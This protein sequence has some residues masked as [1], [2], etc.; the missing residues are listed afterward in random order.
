MV[1]CLKKQANDISGG[2]NLIEI[3]ESYFNYLFKL[4]DNA[5]LLILGIPK[6]VE[7]CPGDLIFIKKR[8][9]PIKTQYSGIVSGTK[10]IGP[11]F[12]FFTF[13]ART[14]N[15]IDFYIKMLARGNTGISRNRIKYLK[16]IAGI[17]S[18]A[19]DYNIALSQLKKINSMF[20]KSLYRILE[21]IISLL[22][23][24]DPYT[25]GHSSNVKRISFLIA[26]EMKLSIPA[27]NRIAVSAVLHD[28]GKIGI[29]DTIL[30]KPCFLDNAEFEE[31]KKH[32]L[33]GGILLEQV[34]NFKDIAKIVM[35]HHERYDG[36]G[37]PMGLSGDNISIEARIIALSDACDAI[38]SRRPYRDKKCLK[39]AV[40][41]IKSGS[42]TQFDPAVVNAFMGL[43]S[44]NFS[45]LNCG[46]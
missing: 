46:N 4:I 39:E 8:G 33:N 20:E 35:Q 43:S 3:T 1:I 24:K 31:V 13:K 6:P 12:F 40:E 32:S 30:Q 23:L 28:I 17:F 19:I 7:S 26:E 44:K 16:E 38:T 21:I 15:N 37:Y 18:D 36:G 27:K 45:G 29:P 10:S 11:G 34:P 2:H 9:L 22:E 41:I 42:G 5:E 14:K 25:F